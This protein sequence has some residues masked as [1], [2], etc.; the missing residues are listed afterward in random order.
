MAKCI[1]V[2]WYTLYTL[3]VHVC[4]H[5]H[6]H[7]QME[8]KTKRSKIVERTSQPQ[9]F[10]LVPYIETKI[11]WNETQINTRYIITMAYDGVWCN[12]MGAETVAVC[13][14][15]MLC[16]LPLNCW[17]ISR[18]CRI[19]NKKTKSASQSCTVDIVLLMFIQLL[20]V[21]NARVYTHTHTQPYAAVLDTH[22]LRMAKWQ[23]AERNDHAK[24]TI[25][26]IRWNVIICRFGCAIY[27]KVR[28]ANQPSTATKKKATNGHLI[29]VSYAWSNEL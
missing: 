8:T 9:S 10:V 14:Q 29:S 21:R 17:S 5:T 22:G 18:A 27:H 2:R 24:S 26:K 3:L 4:G 16:A 20:H 13:L 25:R 15:Y 28:P 1:V 11:N 6:T 7:T 19:D 23:D 12:G